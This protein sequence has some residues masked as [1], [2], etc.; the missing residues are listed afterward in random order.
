MPSISLVTIVMGNGREKHGQILH[1]TL[2]KKPKLASNK[3]TPRV[4]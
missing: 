4:T 2:N 3:Q 1:M